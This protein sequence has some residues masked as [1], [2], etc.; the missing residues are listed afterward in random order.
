MKRSLP[1]AIQAAIAKSSGVASAPK[2]TRRGVMNRTEAAY[3]AELA[4]RKAAG[5]VLDFGFELLKLRLA[6]GAW[7]T[8]DFVVFLP[9]SPAAI[10]LHEVKGFEREAAMLRLKVAASLYPH[11]RFCLVKRVDAGWSRKWIGGT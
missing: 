5:E 8:P 10:E 1:P 11:F 9:T 2:R 3:A 6:D 4:I 7:Y